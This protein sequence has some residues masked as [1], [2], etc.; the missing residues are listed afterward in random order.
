[1]FQALVKLETGDSILAIFGPEGGLSS[2]EV[3]IM[4][5]NGIIPVGFGPRILRT[6]T[7]PLYF[8][9]TVSFVTELSKNN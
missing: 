7:A 3:T 5:E 6:E 4:E 2:A 8:L 1:M 9:A